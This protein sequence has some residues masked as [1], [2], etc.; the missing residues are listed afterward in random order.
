ML[1][2]ALAARHPQQPRPSAAERAAMLATPD[3]ALLDY[4]RHLARLE[5]QPFV[6]IFDEVD[7]LVGEA[8]VSFLTQLRHGYIERSRVPFPAS[9]VL[10]GQ[11]QVRDYA[12]RDED[13]RT[14]QWLGTTS[15]FNISA[16]ATTL[17]ASRPRSRSSSRSTPRPPGSASRPRRSRGSGSAVATRG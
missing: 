14:L 8:M 6:L 5:P 9:V 7:G 4:L 16:E 13:R 17:E 10:V 12:L 11:R 15:P 3:T 2:G 1:D